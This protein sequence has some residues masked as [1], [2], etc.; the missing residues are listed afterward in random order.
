MKAVFDT[1][2]PDGFGTIAPYLFSENPSRLIAFL[3]SAFQA[4][5]LDQTL[6]KETNVILNAILKIGQS[7]FMISQARGEFLGMRTALYLYVE[8][9]DGLYQ[10]AL[11]SGAKDCF[12]P[13]DMDYQDRQAGVMDPDGNYW[14]IS[15][16]L[17]EKGYH[18]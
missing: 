1:Y 10:K 8:D 6:E 7:C 16:R 18:E 9:V 13:A 4:K 15:K 11:E 12:A 5:V 14:W 17:V 2:T 3:E